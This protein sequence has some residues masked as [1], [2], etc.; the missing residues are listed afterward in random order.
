MTTP[1][2]VRNIRVCIA[3]NS[4]CI[5]FK[6]LF[7]KKSSVKLKILENIVSCA[8]TCYIYFTL[9]DFSLYTMLQT[10]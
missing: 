2:L 5:T 3:S 10:L 9:T 6:S 8:S 1:Q 7:L 4:T